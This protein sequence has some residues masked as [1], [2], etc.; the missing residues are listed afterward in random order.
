[1]ADI[2][3]LLKS[4]VLDEQFYRETQ[5]VDGFNWLNTPC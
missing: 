5:Y 1:M 3:I 4:N 2:I